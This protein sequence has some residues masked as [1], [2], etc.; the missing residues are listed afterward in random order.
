MEQIGGLLGGLGVLGIDGAFILGVVTLLVLPWWA[1]FDCA[2]S[3]RSGGVKAIGILLLLFTWG[4]GSLIYGL[5][6]TTSKAMRVA[7]AVA[8]GCVFLL[9]A[10]GGA[11]LIAG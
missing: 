6:V 3:R 4:F 5:F 9:F 10:A 7:T 8:F 11:S 2:F 1:I